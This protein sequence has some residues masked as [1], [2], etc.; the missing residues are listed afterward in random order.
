MGK[1][2]A[3][4]RIKVAKDKI[5]TYVCTSIFCH[6]EIPE[7]NTIV[8]EQKQKHPGVIY[9]SECNSPMRRKVKKFKYKML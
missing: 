8:K 1:N 4:V 3:G 2:P 6:C 9:C 7:S 5:I